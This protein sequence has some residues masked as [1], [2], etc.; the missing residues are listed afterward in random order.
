MQRLSI[1]Q[2]LNPE[3][4]IKIREHSSRN[5]PVGAVFREVDGL[6]TV[7]YCLAEFENKPLLRRWT[8]YLEKMTSEEELIYEVMKS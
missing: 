2:K 6:Y 5:Y 7:V 3:R 4:E 1:S 8:I